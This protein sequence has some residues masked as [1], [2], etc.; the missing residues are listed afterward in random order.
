MSMAERLDRV[1]RRHPAAGLPIAVVY[2]FFDD[3]GTYLA[4]LIAYYGFV[5][6]F[7]A[8]LLLSTVLGYVL[9]GNPGLQQ[10]LLHSA[11]NTA[12][13]V[14]RHH[15]PDPIR[16]RGRSLLLLATMG[17]T[18]LATTVLSALGSSAG[19]FGASLGVVWPV[20]LTATAVLVN[21]GVF[22]LGF[23]IS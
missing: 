16:A 21:A 13:M 8:L 19:A 17:L 20:L 3:S 6:L 7:P 12:W 23:R 4:A 5:S 9:H 14:P 18:V 22:L 10:Q 15:R 1:Q 2:K 11:M